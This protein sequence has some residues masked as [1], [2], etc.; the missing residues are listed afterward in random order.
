MI[1]LRYW[2][3]LGEREKFSAKWDTGTNDNGTITKRLVQFFRVDEPEEALLSA[4][5]CFDTNCKIMV[6]GNHR[7]LW[8]ENEFPILKMYHI[9]L[10]TF[11][12]P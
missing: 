5:T 9:V 6:Q 8:V 3:D 10:L 11:Q 12:H 2:I 7:N 1:K 4:M